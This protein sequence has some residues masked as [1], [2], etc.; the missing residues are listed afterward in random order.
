MK[1]NLA[2]FDIPHRIYTILEVMLHA[3][4]NLNIISEFIQQGLLF[5]I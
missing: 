2:F 5:F 3:L 1:Y 4:W